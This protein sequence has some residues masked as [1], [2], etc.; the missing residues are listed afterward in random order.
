MD[1]EQMR[2][3]T[4]AFGVRVVKLAAALPNGRVGDVLGRQ[5]LRAGTAIGAN[6]HEAIRASSRR[7]FVTMLEVAERE[8]AETL[9]WLDLLSEAELIKPERLAEL[10]D[11]CRQLLAI[12]V[13]TGRTTKRTRTPPDP[14]S[15]I[16][17]PK[18]P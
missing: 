10:H 15:E 9:Y 8:A 5:L 11:E 1:R 6:D 17:N 4:K 7:H 16:R 3:R 14:K 18:S 12:L 2:Q 13:A